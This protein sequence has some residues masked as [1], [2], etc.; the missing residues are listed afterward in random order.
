MAGVLLIT[1]HFPPSAASGAFRLLGFAQH[2][3]KFGYR[4][5]VLAPP[6]LPWEP[7]DVSLGARVPPE[8]MLYPVD[9]PRHASRFLRRLSPYGIWAWYARHTVAHAVR[10]MRPD[11][12]LSSGPPHV[13]HLLGCEVQRRFGI[14]WVLDCRDPWVTTTDVLAPRGWKAAYE[15]F[16]ERRMFA[17]ADAI[18][19]NAPHAHQQLAL[20]LPHFAEKLHTIPNG[21]DPDL[22]PPS[23]LPSP[24]RA[25]GPEGPWFAPIRPNGPVRFLHAG[26][27]YAGRDPRPLLDAVAE[28]SGTQV[29]PLRFEFLGRTEVAGGVNLHEEAM[30]RGLGESIICRGQLSYQQTLA[31][32]STADV[33]V[34]MDTPKR[35]IGVPAKLYEYIG[36]G[37]PVLATGQIDGDLAV[38]LRQ[39]GLPCRIAR[40]DDA[41]AIRDAITELVCGVANGTLPSV[42]D[43]ARRRFAR[44][45]LAGELA[46][47]LDGLRGAKR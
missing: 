10:E 19:C 38:T 44:E 47:V 2:L 3:P 45:T 42:C 40:P 21:Y 20:A 39:S 27:L 14:P 13:V 28:L 26:Q 41:K 12:V 29:P 32:M 9:Y 35:R 11:V 46:T 17:R 23:R 1:Y 7:V 25:V 6:T 15:R 5:G 36:A 30:K 43:E 24:Q 22:F 37:R 33:L 8:T 18:L 31:E 4:V 34:L 16:W